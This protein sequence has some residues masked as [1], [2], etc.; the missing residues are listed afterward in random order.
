MDTLTF[1]NVPVKISVRN[2]LRKTRLRYFTFMGQEGCGYLKDYLNDRE[3]SDEILKKESAWLATDQGN[4]QTSQ[5]FL[6]T[7]LIGREI[8][9]A[10]RNSDLSMRLYVLRAYFVTALDI[11]ESKGHISHPLRQYL[12]GHKRE[13]EATYSTNKRSLPETIEG[14]RSAY[15][16]CTKFFETE[17]SGVREEDYQE[18]FRDSAIDT[19]T[20][21]FGLTPT[22]EQKEEL[23]NLDTTE[24]QKKLGEIFK[25]RKADILNTDNS[26][27]VVP[28]KEVEKYNK[29][30]WEYVRDFAGDK[31]IVKLPS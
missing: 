27:K 12:I 24:Y 30:G 23:R 5:G 8:R 7:A 11:A 22:E 14:M 28:F 16:K 26:Q 29:Q 3:A 13:I 15:L 20:G 9:K 19:L 1:N 25:D 21:A 31:S 10:M 6:R 2:G 17:E 4:I 18:M